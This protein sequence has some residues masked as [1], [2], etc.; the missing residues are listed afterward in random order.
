MSET[1]P[2][3]GQY[4]L[5]QAIDHI[6]SFKIIG[7]LGLTEAKIRKWF[8]KKA[9]RKLQTLFTTNLILPTSCTWCFGFNLCQSHV[10]MC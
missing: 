1:M 4:V 6:E 7:H 8:K 3:F 10:A 9:I 5:L 2:A